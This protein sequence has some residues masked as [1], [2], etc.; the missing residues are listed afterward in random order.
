LVY[1]Q[2][3]LFQCLAKLHPSITKKQKHWEAVELMW[4]Q[5]LSDFTFYS[6]GQQ[7]LPKVEHSHLYSSCDKPSWF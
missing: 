2:S 6:E 4:L 1:F 3:N 7:T 5:F